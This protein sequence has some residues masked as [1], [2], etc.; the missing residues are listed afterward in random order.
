MGENVQGRNR[1]SKLL[2]P[3]SAGISD[4]IETAHDGTTS[5]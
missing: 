3:I 5:R 4:R 1:E 2:T